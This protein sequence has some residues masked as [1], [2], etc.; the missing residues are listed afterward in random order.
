MMIFVLPKFIHTMLYFSALEYVSI[1]KRSFVGNLALAI[2]FPFGGIIQP[3]VLKAVKDWTIFH[4]I[5]FSQTCI[6]LI[7]APW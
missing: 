6:F 5:F 3:W 2:G 7:A 1:K 4:H